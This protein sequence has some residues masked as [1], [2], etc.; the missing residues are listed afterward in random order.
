MGKPPGSSPGQY[1]ADPGALTSIMLFGPGTDGK[2]QQTNQGN[3][4][5]IFFYHGNTFS[6]RIRADLLPVAQKSI[7]PCSQ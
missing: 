1:Q 4:K 3:Q 6:I 2:N 7:D 5:K